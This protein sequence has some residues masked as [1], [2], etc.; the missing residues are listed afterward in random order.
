MVSR[1]SKDCKKFMDS[2]F[3]DS[4]FNDVVDLIPD[5]VSELDLFLGKSFGRY[6]M[7]GKC[8]IDREELDRLVKKELISG[9]V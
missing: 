5:D 8:D 2:M 1:V 6:I 9:R 7:Y 4:I 3:R